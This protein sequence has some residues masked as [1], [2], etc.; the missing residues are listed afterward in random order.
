MHR[1]S[2]KCTNTKYI[3]YWYHFNKTIK[4]NKFCCVC[5]ILPRNKTNRSKTLGHNLTNTRE[6]YDNEPKRPV[7]GKAQHSSSPGALTS[8]DSCHCCCCCWDCTRI[9][10]QTPHPSVICMCKT[11]PLSYLRDELADW[12][13]INQ[14]WKGLQDMSSWAQIRHRSATIRSVHAF[15]W[16]CGYIRYIALSV[17]YVITW[18]HL[19]NSEV[20]TV[21]QGHHKKTRPQT[22]TG[23]MH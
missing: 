12:L 22:D 14:W 19:Q 10:C 1:P 18:C 23:N 21:S 20:Y 9:I 11:S 5:D 6:N 3:S 13:D 15:Q 17:Q 7:F 8:M 2:Y 4:D 16:S